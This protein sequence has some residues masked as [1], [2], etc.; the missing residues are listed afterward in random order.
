M[1]IASASASSAPTFPDF[2]SSVRTISPTWSLVACPVPTIDFFT[3]FAAYSCTS[4]PS[5]AKACAI[6]MPIAGSAVG[7]ALG[8]FIGEQL[9]WRWAFL[10]VGVPGSL[11]AL[12][13]IGLWLRIDHAGLKYVALARFG[14]VAVRLLFNVEVL[15]YHERGAWRVLNWLMYTYLVPAGAMVASIGLLAKHERARLR[16]WEPRLSSGDP[17][18]ASALGAAAIAVVFVWVNLTI[19]DWFSAERLLELSFERLPARD[20]T[21][22]IAWALYGIG[23]LLLG[24][25]RNA[26][27]LRRASLALILITCCKVFLYDLAHLSDLYRVVSLVGLALSLILVSLLYK[28]LVASQEAS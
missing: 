9:G 15:G 22:S 19:V 5:R 12:A 13:M 2:G 24:M 18:T 21:L 16:D 4:S 23:L 3:R 11:L 26:A 10:I 1:A 6:S 8:G 7:L 28:R 20:L 25:W 14:C 17:I 27:G